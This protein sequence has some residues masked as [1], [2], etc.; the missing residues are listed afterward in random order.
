MSKGPKTA[1]ENQPIPRTGPSTTSLTKPREGYQV[2]SSQHS[3]RPKNEVP[4]NHPKRVWGIAQVL[5]VFLW[6]AALKIGLSEY[7]FSRGTWF[8]HTVGWVFSK[9]E[10]P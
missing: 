2:R 7:V 5:A 8:L 3:G 1:F 4:D 6:N 10:Q 9:P